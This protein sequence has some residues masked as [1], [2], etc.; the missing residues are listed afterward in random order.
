MSSPT[1]SEQEAPCENHCR[2][3]VPEASGTEKYWKWA[4][5]VLSVV[6]SAGAITSVFGK[7]FYV[8][9]DEYTTRASADAVAS[10]NMRGTLERLDKTLNTQ[11][12]AFSGL[13]SEVQGLKIGFAVMQKNH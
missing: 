10:E 1:G 3:S 11:A 13:A 2:Y 5:L 6:L 4:A 7:A 12:A 8:T 9:R